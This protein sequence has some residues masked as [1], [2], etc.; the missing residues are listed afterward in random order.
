MI[1]ICEI[2]MRHKNS[3]RLEVSKSRTLR[4]ATQEAG[5]YDWPAIQREVDAAFAKAGELCERCQTEIRKQ[6]LAR[7]MEKP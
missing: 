5:K 6:H 7:R 2:A 1:D 3:S 4:V